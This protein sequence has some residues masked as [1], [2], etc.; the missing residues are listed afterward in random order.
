MAKTRHLEDA[1]EEARKEL[2]GTGEQETQETTTETT[3]ASDDTS[4]EDTTTEETTTTTGQPPEDKPAD[5][6][7]DK[8]EDTPA[9]GAVDDL[10]DN[11]NSVIRRRLSKQ[12]EKYESELK[13]R[14]DKYEALKKQFEE[15]KASMPKPEPKKLTRDQ[16]ETDEDFVA[17]LTRQQLE[18]SWAE[19][20]QQKKDQ[21]AKD[22]AAREEQERVEAEARAR[23]ERFARNVEHCFGDPEQRKQF[24]STVAYYTRK[25]LGTLLDACPMAGDYLL[26]NPRGPHVLNRLLND[27]EAFKRVFDPEGITPLDQY[28]EL[29][30]LER[31]MFPRNPPKEEPE[32]PAA[33]AQ[34][35]APSK[36]AP[37]YGKPG[38]QGSGRSADVFTDPKARRD[39]VRRLMGF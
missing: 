37:R 27:K 32:Q 39:E 14:D 10:F 31:E 26:G 8:P 9:T 28:D 15:F 11:A 24:M 35:A 20:D 7:E 33:P 13:E 36:A 1:L 16:F 5:K 30:A 25:G 2:E 29:K 6:P 12:A 19:R 23:Q 18:A 3:Q 22:A 38:A 21:D 34:P 17:A 4:T